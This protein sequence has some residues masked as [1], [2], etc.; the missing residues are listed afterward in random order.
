MFDKIGLGSLTDNL[1]A[2]TLAENTADTSEQ[3]HKK[4]GRKKKC[5]SDVK[6]EKALPDDERIA[7]LKIAAGRI[8]DLV[9]QFSSD[10]TLFVADD[11]QPC[12][13]RLD[14]KTLKEFT[15]VIKEVGGVICELYGITS[16]RVEDNNGVKIEFT[17]E[18]QEYAE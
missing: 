9:C 6:P 7:P 12:K 14:T 15:S 2:V 3:V 17:G 11:T 8:A 16:G 10:S 1:A 13:R 5:S 18:T 4:R